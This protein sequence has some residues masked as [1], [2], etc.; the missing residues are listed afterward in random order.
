MK[1]DTINI[2]IAD[3]DQISSMVLEIMLN[4]LGHTNVTI[5]ESPKAAIKSAEYNAFDLILMDI[6]FG[7][8]IDGIQAY[9][10]ISNFRDIPVI[11]MT[12]V[13]DN[14]VYN[15]AK[16]TDFLEFIIKPVLVTSLSSALKKVKHI[17][18]KAS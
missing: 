5:V 11:Y 15:R 1:E 4:H 14:E 16:E 8:G 6:H 7:N 17:K 18:K 2:L 10:Q 12:S 3:D 9:K 13:S